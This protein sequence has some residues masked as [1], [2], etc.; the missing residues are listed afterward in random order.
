MAAAQSG[1]DGSFTRYW[2]AATISSF[3]TAV[4]AVAMPVLVVQVL[5]ASPVEVGIVNAAQFVPYAVLGLLAGVYVDRWR[6]RRVLVW[7]SVGRGL[8]LGLI[9]VLWLTG[10]LEIWS[11]VVLLLIFG[12]LAVF[13]LAASQSL[14]PQIVPRARLLSANSR[15]DQTDAAA[16]TAGPALG[17]GLVGLLGAPVTIAIDAVSYLVEAAL[18]ARLRL[19]EPARASA[20]D[21]PPQPRSVRREIGQGLRWTY[22]HVSLAPLAISTHLW[23]F[24]NAGALTVLALFALRDL[25]LSPAAYGLLFAVAGITT[26]VGAAVAPWA[27]RSIGAGRS[28]VIARV[29]YPVAWLLI[30]ATALAGVGGAGAL[31]A[32]FVALAL[33]GFVAGLENP[34]EMAYRQAVTPDALLGRTNATMRSANRTMAAL[35][36]LVAGVVVAATGIAPAL[37]GVVVVFIAAGVVAVASPLRHARHDDGDAAA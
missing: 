20:A 31:V 3:G 7:A 8:A 2:V 17:G 12:S 37:V 32:L 23:F 35:G 14:L 4:T 34:N 30:A 9:P 27:G 18:I 28:I 29:V 26:L 25:A 36:A 6:R 24:A 22:R 19:T 1:S 33:Q 5:G 21:G 11:L 15:L 10:V 16:Q 13:G